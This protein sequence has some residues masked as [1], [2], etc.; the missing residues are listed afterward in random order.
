MN[1]GKAIAIGLAIGL[2]V[3]VAA[4][5][6]LTEWFAPGATN[7]RWLAV[8]II[9]AIVWGVQIYVGVKALI[10]THLFKN[11]AGGKAL[12]AQLVAEGFPPAERHDNAERYLNSISSDFDLPDDLRLKASFYRGELAAAG[13]AGITRSYALHRMWDQ[14]LGHLQK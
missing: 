5:W 11:E 14:A 10:V 12:A 9:V 3:D 8:G 2:A 6:L 7:D 1:A 13:Q 4:A